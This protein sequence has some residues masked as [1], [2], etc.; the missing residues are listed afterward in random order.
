MV[1]T[2]VPCLKVKQWLKEWDNLDY[3][4]SQNR[5][6][7]RSEIFI[8]KMKAGLLRSLSGV[9]RRERSGVGSA[10]GLQRG[11]DRE[12]S[13]EIGKFLRFGYPWSE[14]SESKRS[15]QE[16]ADLRKPGWLPNSIVIN[17][18]PPTDERRGRSVS[19]RDQVVINDD[20]AKTELLLPAG[21]LE[22][23][24]TPE[25][26]PPFEV[27]D[28]Q[29][30]LWAFSEV[31]IDLDFELPVVAFYGLDVSWQAYL[32]WSINVSPKRIN[33][34]HAFD[35]Y[36]LL[37]TEDWLYKFEG[38]SIYRQARAQELVDLLFSHPASPWLDRIN[39]LGERGL[40]QISQAAWVNSLMATFLATG[41]GR[42]A[43]GLFGANVLGIQGPLPWTRPQ[44]A[45]FLMV[46][47]DALRIEISRNT[48]EWALSIRPQTNQ[49]TMDFWG[50]DPDPAFIGQHS[51]LNQDQGVR[52]YLSVVNDIFANEAEN[53]SLK[54]WNL[55][56]G[57]EGVSNEEI[58]ASIA[59]LKQQLFVEKIFELAAILATFDW[60]T[61]E[62]PGLTRDQSLLKKAFRGTGGYS[63]I[64]KELHHFLASYE[65]WGQDISRH[66]LREL[67]TQ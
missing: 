10:T 24:W 21:C 14:M 41:K 62:A 22:A 64:R 37:R 33:P 59:S 20:G 49:D 45:A 3:D 11:H 60:R 5:R 1:Q 34:S 6:K 38:H 52:G 2:A 17:I 26:L 47:W 25:D 43:K 67:E 28:G 40:K 32:F 4:A 23:G 56:P 46:I 35:L 19:Q 27:I 54:M 53:L 58:T 50:S 31:D 55:P 29:H 51:L 30:R 61:S 65:W 39:M 8:F 7:P 42:S 12:R 66:L 44:Q 57:I 48:T 16:F 63:T 36:P 15:D 9:F 18:L 13:A